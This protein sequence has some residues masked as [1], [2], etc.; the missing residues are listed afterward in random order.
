MALMEALVNQRKNLILILVKKDPNFASVYITVKIIVIGL[1]TEK[2]SKSLK[3]MN[4]ML[5]VLEKSL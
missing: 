2:K 4:L 5:L 3:L 1:L